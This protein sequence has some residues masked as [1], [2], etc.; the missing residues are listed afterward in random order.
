MPA[1]ALPPKDLAANLAQ[2]AAPFGKSIML[3]DA[4][5]VD[6]FRH[7]KG[8]VWQAMI[9]ID[10]V[11]QHLS[12]DVLDEAGIIVCFVDHEQLVWSFQEIIGLGT[13]RGLNDP[14]QVLCMHLMFG[15]DEE[16]AASAL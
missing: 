7:D 11:L 12:H 8:V 5:E 6:L 2:R 14:D 3:V 15:P 4:L 13:H 9:N 10:H 16:C 1:H